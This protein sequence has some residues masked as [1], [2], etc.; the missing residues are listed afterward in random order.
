MLEHLAIAGDS[1]VFAFGTSGAIVYWKQNQWHSVSSGTTMRIYDAWQSADSKSG[2]GTILA[3]A[4]GP[5]PSSGMKLLKVNETSVTA[6]PDSGLL[7]YS[8]S[9]WFVANTS[10]Y[11]VG[12]G[13]FSKT[14]LDQAT[15]RTDL[16]PAI[17]NAF[18]VRVRGLGANDVFV[19]GSY[20]RISHFNGASWHSYSNVISLPQF[21]LGGLAV[22]DHTVMVTGSD[23]QQAVVLIGKR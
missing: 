1:T 2:E 20:G 5:N 16:S 19:V 14:S 10:Y 11:I 15:W 17:Q 23:G 12:P 6:L 4:A 13:V 7:W 18:W 22:H 9:I 3:I 21:V 8:V